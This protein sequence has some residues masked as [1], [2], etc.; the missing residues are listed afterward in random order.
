MPSGGLAGQISLGVSASSVPREAIDAA[1]VCFDRAPKRSDAKL[2]PHVMVYFVMALALFGGEDYEEVAL[3]DN[4]I[5]AA[6][7]RFRSY[8]QG[9]AG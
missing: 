4:L 9:C 6:Q 7:G 5:R 1:A 3:A 8:G 2:P